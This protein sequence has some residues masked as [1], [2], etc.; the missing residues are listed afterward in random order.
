MKKLV[1][2]FLFIFLIHL[3]WTQLIY[4]ILQF[5]ILISTCCTFQ[6]CWS[7]VVWWS[8]CVIEQGQT[9]S[10]TKSVSDN[11][12]VNGDKLPKITYLRLSTWPEIHT[13][14]L[15][16]PDS[17]RLMATCWQFVCICEL[18]SSY[19]QTLYSLSE[20]V[21]KGCLPSGDLCK[22]SRSQNVKKSIQSAGSHSF[23]FVDARFNHGWVSE[24]LACS[25]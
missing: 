19:L 24:L 13:K 7:V 6:H 4:H 15:Q 22:C 8:Q 21:Q 1:P 5:V 23:L 10:H 20:H 16:H 14:L 17:F 18:D 25:Q 2:L 3:S 11:A 9:G 12:A